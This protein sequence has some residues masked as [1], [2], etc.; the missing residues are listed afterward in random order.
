MLTKELILEK[1]RIAIGDANV[2]DQST[3]ENTD[4]W[5]SLGQLEILITLSKL[6]NG[7]SDLVQGIDDFSS[8][9][10]L[11]ELLSGQAIIE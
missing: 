4:N 11:F 2:T 6:T 8:I 5:D 3:R 9:S 10:E 1:I 7:A